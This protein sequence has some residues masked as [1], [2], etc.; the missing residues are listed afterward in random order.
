M[1]VAERDEGIYRALSAAREYSGRAV[2]REGFLDLWEREDKC[3]A[4]ASWGYSWMKQ[5]NLQH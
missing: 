4:G 1:A 2:S 3:K 5:F